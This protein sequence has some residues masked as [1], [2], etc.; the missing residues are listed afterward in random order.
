MKRFCCVSLQVDSGL[1][2]QS[3]KRNAPGE[4]FENIS[5]QWTPHS[6]DSEILGLQKRLFEVKYKN[7]TWVLVIVPLHKLI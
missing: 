6:Q 2:G 7:R 1:E 3:A 5:G 4:T